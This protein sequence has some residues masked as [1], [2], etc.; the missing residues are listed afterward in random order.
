MLD[1]FAVVTNHPQL[2]E[3]LCAVGILMLTVL[4][5]ILHRTRMNARLDSALTL[6]TIGLLCG[7]IS[8]LGGGE[9]RGGL[10]L[11]AYAVFVAAISIGLVHAALVLFVDFYLRERQGAA[12][13]TIFRDVASLIIY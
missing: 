10:F 12:V 3:G 2:S 1:W 8:A 9:A 6:L 11:Y 4:R 5:P 13:S 7:A